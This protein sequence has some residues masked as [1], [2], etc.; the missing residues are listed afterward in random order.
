[1]DILSTLLSFPDLSCQ[2][3]SAHLVGVFPPFRCCPGSCSNFTRKSLPLRLN[4]NGHLISALECHPISSLII[5]ITVTVTLTSTNS[6]TTLLDTVITHYYYNILFHSILQTTSEVDITV[7][8][9]LQTRKCMPI[10]Y[11]C[12]F[13][14]SGFCLN[15]L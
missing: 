10:E 7:I 4:S 9:I 3:P 2:T 14:T 11:R 15:A 13:I 6:A 1:M 12:L 5:V 8:S